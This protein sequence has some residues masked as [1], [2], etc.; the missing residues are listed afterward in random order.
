MF[1]HYTLTHL[2]QFVEELYQRN[3]ILSPQQLNIEEVA[4]RLNIWIYFS[5]LGSKAVEIREG[6]GSINIFK[7]QSRTLRWLDFLH[8]L[9]HLLRHAGDQTIMPEQ[10]TAAQE[11]EADHF[12]LYASMPFFMIR[13]MHLPDRRNEAIAYIA[14]EF[15]V[16]T[17]IAEKRVDQIYRRIL[18]GQL[19][20]VANTTSRPIQDTDP[21]NEPDTSWSDETRRILS[22]LHRQLI[23]RGKAASE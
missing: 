3:G 20:E 13:Q 7:Y 4:R 22:Q 6:L 23:T 12:V 8:E 2:E 15:R 5:G 10:F 19:L 14:S 9:C 21:K 18:R 16:T 1:Q 11:A 17:E